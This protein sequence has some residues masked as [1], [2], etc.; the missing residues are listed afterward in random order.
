MINSKETR[1]E[2][3]RRFTEAN[4]IKGLL[5]AMGFPPDRIPAFENSQLTWQRVFDLLEAGVLE[6]G[7]QKLYAMALEMYPANPIFQKA[8]DTFSNHD[9]QPQTCTISVPHI[10]EADATAKL[11]YEVLRELRLEATFGFDSSDALYL[12][13]SSGLND[14]KRM[15]QAIGLRL[16]THGID[17]EVGVAPFKDVLLTRITIEGPDQCLFELTEVP[18]ST[19]TIDVIDIVLR[20]YQVDGRTP[21]TTLNYARTQETTPQG[22]T[23]ETVPQD[24]T[25]EAPPQGTS[26]S[27]LPGE[28]F[29]H[30]NHH[31]INSQITSVSVDNARTGRRL[32]HNLTLLENMI[33]SDDHLTITF[34]ANA[35]MNVTDYD[36]YLACETTPLSE[37]CYD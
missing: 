33:A 28:V 36:R 5:F 15:A 23:P 37:Y 34:G 8:N 31:G 6:Q 12:Y 16:K 17:Q 2:I 24:T 11:V 19:K 13:V 22:T 18:A 25:I 26:T 21:R 29:K 1:K 9:S 32:A 14:A 10:S 4:D 35:G 3:Q 7:F 20:H 30:Q 27:A